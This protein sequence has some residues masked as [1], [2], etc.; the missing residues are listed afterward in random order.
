M[1]Q[2]NYEAG[3][4]TLGN[5]EPIP[6][7]DYLAQVVESDVVPTKAGTGSQLKLKWLVLDGE[8]SGRFIF[9]RVTLTNPNAQAMEIGRKQL[10]TIC[11]AVGL[12]HV[13]DSVELHD[14]PAVI[15]VRIKPADGQY[16]AS[17]EVRG[18]KSA[19]GDAPAPTPA[20][21]A[22]KPAATAAKTA[23]APV[24]AKPAWLKK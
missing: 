24:G 3:N 2:L 22:V 19:E 20:P 10:N 11:H 9:D 14:R 12:T 13:G 6:A 4:E 17:N 1:A 21:A 18:Y 15:T 16:A 7:G 23:P 8:Y 5:Y